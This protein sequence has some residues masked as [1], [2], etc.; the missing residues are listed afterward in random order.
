[1]TGDAPFSNPHLEHVAHRRRIGVEMIGDIRQ[2]GVVPI[3][4]IIA[5]IGQNH[6]L[7]SA[8]RNALVPLRL[9]HR[10]NPKMIAIKADSSTAIRVA[11]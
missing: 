9:P 10:L 3:T 4:Q 11:D 7:D 8:D 1:M 5:N 6:A 2:A